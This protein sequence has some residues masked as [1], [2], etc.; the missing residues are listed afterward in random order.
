MSMSNTLTRPAGSLDVKAEQSTAETADSEAPLV[1]PVLVLREAGERTAEACATQL[2]RA[3]GAPVHRV[4]ERPFEAALRRSL[5]LGRRADAEWLLVLDAD[6]LPSV[7]ALRQFVSAAA[8]QPASVFHCQ[9]WILDR[10]TGYRYAGNRLYRTAAIADALDAIGPVGSELR[11]ET[12]MIQALEATGRR[13]VMPRLVL[14]LH[15]F[16]QW[17]RDIR[18]TCL[19]HAFKHPGYLR[20]EVLVW[21][22]RASAEPD[23]LSALQG[24][25]A[26]LLTLEEVG[27]DAERLTQA[28]QRW[29]QFPGE[30]AEKPPLDPSADLESLIALRLADAGSPD[31]R[32]DYPE[33]VRTARHRLLD[34]VGRLGPLRS[35]PWLLGRGLEAAG[36]GLQTWSDVPDR[37]EPAG[38][39][40]TAGVQR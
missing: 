23:F 40:A 17:H 36:V 20:Q 28:A 34:R 13:T 6:V 3:F 15:D 29:T 8:A 25:A 16:E 1:A 30:F 24:F 22:R 27:L 31:Y 12:A 21:R 26:G 9:S 38:G 4:C 10:F 5:E 18:R 19:L 33:T 14:G 37:P 11:P 2:E 32:C 39:K 7:E 35:L